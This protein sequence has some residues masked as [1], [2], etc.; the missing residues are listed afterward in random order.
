MKKITLGIIAH[1]DSGKTTLSEALLYLT[2]TI[3]KF[4]R[5]DKG[6][7][8]LD[9]QDM[10]RRR[11]ITIYSKQARFDWQDTQ[12]VLIDTPGHADFSA[13][14][15]RTLQVLDYAV[16]L[17]SASDGIQG[18]TESVW[19]LLQR[20]EIPVF[21]FFNK[22][23]QPGADKDSLMQAFR[24]KLSSDA[25]DFTRK[26]PD[27]WY[28]AIAMCSEEAMEQFL[29]TGGIEDDLIREMIRQRQLFP[30]FFGSALKQE[31]VEAFLQALD[32]Y[33]VPGIY[34]EEF[35]AR[36][37]KI[38]RDPD[39]SRLTMM[40]ITG[41]VL[42]ART[43]LPDGEADGKVHQIRIYSGS[44]FTLR[45]EVKAGEIC[46]VTGLKS[47]F[48][49]Q[50]FGLEAEEVLPLVVPVLRYRAV[51]P[52]GE[53]PV[54]ALGHFRIL[55]EEN[56][57]LSVAWEEEHQAIYV[58][59]MGEVQLQILTSLLAERFG[60][61]VSFDDGEIMY[62][63][64]IARPVIG[65]GHFEPLRHYA[66]VQFLLEPLERGS[67]IVLDNLAD[68]DRLAA[69]W[70]RLILTNLAEK[71]HRGVLTG[72]PIT[73]V[74]ITLLTGKAHLKHTE[75]G[76]F[77]QA[78]YRAVRQG[79][80]MTEGILLEPYYRF[81]LS[82]PSENVGRAL[83]DLDRAGASFESPRIDAG[84]QMAVITGRGP[85]SSLKDYT[86]E[87]TAYT[88]GRGQLQ[89]TADGYDTCLH[90]QEVI[91]ARGYDPLADVRNTPDSVFCTHGSGYIVPFDEVY[92][93]LH[94]PL[95]GYYA[96]YLPREL[97]GSG[98]PQ[99]VP[100]SDA[101]RPD[102]VSEPNRN[103]GTDE[104]DEII[105]RISGANRRDNR[106][107]SRKRSGRPGWKKPGSGAAAMTPWSD[108]S[109]KAAM[110]QSGRSKHA[111]MAGMTNV[112]G[113]FSLEQAE[114]VIVDGY[115]VIFAWQELSDLARVNIDS[116]RDALIDILSE[117]SSMIPGQVT[118]VFDAYKVRGHSSERM[119]LQNIQILFTS[120]DETA[121]QYIERF[122]NEYGRRRRIAV[123][124]SDGLEQI[125]TRGQGCLLISSRELKT[126]M[127]RLR[128]TL[129]E[130]YD[131]KSQ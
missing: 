30:C 1:V 75:G 95:G 63:E 22:M 93:H 69:N 31:G 39:G 23:D 55:E 113:M 120:Q 116:A 28:D 49:G 64:T 124:T 62:R 43:V 108:S 92:Q 65:A 29:E 74:R 51:L 20:Y 60:I 100:L 3:R 27:Q 85:V 90:A 127:D 41:G 37:Y 71:Q 44:R 105:S 34:P 125:I 6:A 53:D 87:V 35:G 61:D 110:G 9:D 45:D 8:F 111:G 98:L 67:G 129:R 66:E 101:D 73:D 13:E 128:S 102:P 50:G 126:H 115:N 78:V 52:A 10:E 84:S 112:S 109:A 46:A 57:E 121:D 68:T 33:T 106:K 48:A 54:R 70:Q 104:I 2:G 5:V 97:G 83:S 59:V 40:K 25:V 17:T 103:I 4:G 88:R 80:M 26:D 18:Q 79:L 94:T 21:V 76:D 42:K 99:D 123:I 114:C 7:S 91:D 15:E 118:A 36:V 81:F 86:R 82:I 130:K 16:L 47:S 117:L 32:H 122:T 38:T 72:S 58:S 56:P 24:G 131:I 12:F 11:G 19:R 89:L 77:R 107:D 96:G 119:T 14:M